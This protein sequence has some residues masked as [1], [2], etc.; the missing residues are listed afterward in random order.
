[1]NAEILKDGEIF[2]MMCTANKGKKE[3]GKRQL[4]GQTR[5]V[6]AEHL[7]KESTL[8]YR[9]KTASELMGSDDDVESPH[10]Y[11]ASVCR[12]AKYEVGKKRYRKADPLDAIS[13]LK[14]SQM[15]QNVIREIGKDPVKV[16]FWSPH[17]VRVF[18][19]LRKQSSLCIDASGG[20]Y[21]E[22]VHIDGLK[23][24]HIF[25]HIAVLHS[26]FGQLVVSS[27]LTEKQDMVTITAW[28]LRWLQ[29]GA[30]NP[31]K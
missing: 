6:L 24:Q 18:N 21:M 31:K 16:L 10:L 5:N 15:G 19:K 13:D 7:E 22:Y 27:M 26:P 3:C 8:Y 23:S 9:T 30:Q 14:R 1:L 25:L 28:L 20:R 17:Q 4:R 11:Y 29:T 2:K 12:N